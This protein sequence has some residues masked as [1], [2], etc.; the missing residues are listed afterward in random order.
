MLSRHKDFILWLLGTAFTV[1]II[2][3]VAWTIEKRID[4]V[5]LFKTREPASVPEE[6][7]SKHE[8]LYRDFHTSAFKGKPSPYVD[9]RIESPDQDT[10]VEGGTMN[11]VATVRAKQDL[12]NFRFTWFLPRMGVRL[13]SGSLEGELSSLKAGEETTLELTIETE[14]S[15]NR[16]IHLHVYKLA[17]GR[18]TGKMTQFNTSP[19]LAMKRKMRAKAEV[20]EQMRKAGGRTHKIMQ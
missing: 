11:L 19:D 5:S 4:P 14:T 20:L 7:Q 8:T 15:E 3:A 9:V 18:A 2:M 12:E 1:A 10:A 6:T 16:R 13:V 17:N